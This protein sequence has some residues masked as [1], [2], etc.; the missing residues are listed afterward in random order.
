MSHSKFDRNMRPMIRIGCILL[1]AL[2][3]VSAREIQLRVLNL[4][5]RELGP[6]VY[7]HGGTTEDGAKLNPKT[8]LNHEFDRVEVTKD[9]ITLTASA[10]AS[11]VGNPV[12]VLATVTVPEGLNSAILI[13][14]PANKGNPLGLRLL[15]D[16][17]RAFPA[18]SYLLVNL[19]TQPLRVEMAAGQTDLPAEGQHSFPDFAAVDRDAALV[20]VS[21]QNP[22]GWKR[23]WS[24]EWHSLGDKRALQIALSGARGGRIE[25][26]GIKDVKGK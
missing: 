13:C 18:G 24:G 22:Q 26:R 1:L 15:D 11:S 12:A 8:F 20:V 9:E 7:A 4:A 3:S 19:S 2:T 17:E 5:G 25:L 16:S 21:A 23:L 14:T 10:S 6:L